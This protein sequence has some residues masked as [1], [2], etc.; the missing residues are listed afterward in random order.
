MTREANDPYVVCEI[1]A[2]ELGADAGFDAE[3]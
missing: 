1:F 3:S 2:A